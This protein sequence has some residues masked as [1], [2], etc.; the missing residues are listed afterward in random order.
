MMGTLPAKCRQDL[1]EKEGMLSYFKE[2]IH[3]LVCKTGFVSIPL[4]IMGNLVMVLIGRI[5]K[6]R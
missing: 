2:N 6:S 4:C 1:T 3:R 5:N